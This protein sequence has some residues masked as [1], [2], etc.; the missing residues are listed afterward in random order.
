[1]EKEFELNVF[2]EHPT[3]PPHPNIPEP[4]VI[5]ICIVGVA[6]FFLFRWRKQ[7]SPRNVP[8]KFHDLLK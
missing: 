3:H 2:Q 7:F 4:S 6:L 8:I 5:A 1:M